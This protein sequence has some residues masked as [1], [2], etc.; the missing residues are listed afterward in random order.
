MTTRRWLRALAVLYPC[1][2]ALA[3]LSTGNHFL[4]DVLAGLLTLAVSVLIVRVTTAGWDA[5]RQ[6][7]IGR[8]RAV[9]A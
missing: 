6:R 8:R 5:S 9:S 2:T 3:V 7:R 1:V 4:L